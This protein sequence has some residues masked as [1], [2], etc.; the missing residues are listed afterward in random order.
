MSFVF[1]IV[2][3]TQAPKEVR[4]FKFKDQ[5]VLLPDWIVLLLGLETMIAEELAQIKKRTESVNYQDFFN[6]CLESK[7]QAESLTAR[8]FLNSFQREVIQRSL[9]RR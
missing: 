6:R 2:G 1:G 7:H 3:T 9:Q 5:T 4:E 8:D